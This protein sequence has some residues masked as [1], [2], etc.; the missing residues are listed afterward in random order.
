MDNPDPHC[1]VRWPITMKNGLKLYSFED[2]RIEPETAIG[3]SALEYSEKLLEVLRS[4]VA[5]EL[6]LMVCYIKHSEGEGRSLFVTGTDPET[7][8][9]AVEYIK[10]FGWQMLFSQT[11]MLAEAQEAEAEDEDEEG[12][13]D[14]E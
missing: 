12:N 5:D 4:G 3:A 6:Q 9:N 13:D 2:Q 1:R 8:P 11:K 10:N 14:D 7:W